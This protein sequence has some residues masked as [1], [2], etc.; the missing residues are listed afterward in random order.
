MEKCLP[1][2]RYF[3]VMPRLW[4][5]AIRLELV[6]VIPGNATVADGKEAFPPQHRRKGP[7]NKIYYEKC[8][9]RP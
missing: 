4:V 1:T 8:E 5:P 6:I 2:K 7:P 9:L 3:C